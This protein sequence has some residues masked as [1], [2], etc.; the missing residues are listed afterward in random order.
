MSVRIL[1]DSD[2]DVAVLFCSTTDWAF[3]PV[4]TDGDDHDAVERAEAFL[5]W[6]VIDPRMLDEAILISR[7]FHHELVGLSKFVRTPNPQLRGSLEEGGS[8]T[9]SSV[10]Y[11]AHR[12]NGN[13]ERISSQLPNRP[14][15]SVSP[16][17]L[18]SKKSN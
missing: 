8:L 12:F 9:D 15:T 13:G 17:Q 6:L 4:I 3:G 2:Q 14:F 10:R 18:F 5:R 16:A 7:C 1:H 11:P